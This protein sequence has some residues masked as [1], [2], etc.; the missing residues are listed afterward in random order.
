MVQ[1]GELV[2]VT[3]GIPMGTPGSTNIAKIHRVE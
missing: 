2:V 1:R 3:A